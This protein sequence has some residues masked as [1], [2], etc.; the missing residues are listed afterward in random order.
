MIE[1]IKTVL[2]VYLLLESDGCLLFI[3]RQN[4]GWQDGRYTVPAGHVDQGE[5]ASA[6]MA[7]EA[8]EEIGITVNPSDLELAHVMHRNNQQPY[9]DIY[10][11]CLNWT[12]SPQ[13]MEPNKAGDLLWAPL[14]ALPSDVV[15]TVYQAVQAA[16]KGIF[17]SEDAWGSAPAG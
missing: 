12:G 14:E 3:R 17:Y 1:R 6:A 10:F 7:R 13:I 15:P 5:S 4:S 2:A 11:R 8:D 9:L 16:Q